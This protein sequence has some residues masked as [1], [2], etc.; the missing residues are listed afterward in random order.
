LFDA[1]LAPTF[2]DAFID[3]SK[4]VVSSGLVMAVSSKS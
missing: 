3:D 2:Y 1:V 4:D